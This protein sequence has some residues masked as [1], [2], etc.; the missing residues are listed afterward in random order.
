MRDNFPN[1]MD[2]YENTLDFTEDGSLTCGVEFKQD[3]PPYMVGLD[4]AIQYLED[5]FDEYDNQ[6][7]L[8]MSPATGLHTNIGYIG[9]EGQMTEDYNL[10][11]ALMFLNHTYATK[12]VGFPSRE[13]SGWTGDLK[14]PALHNILKLSLI[15]I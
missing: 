15:H 2:K 11:K 14:K 13:R 5:F 3:N 1:F 6:S 9:A 4:A 8:R 12:G 10:F 7:V